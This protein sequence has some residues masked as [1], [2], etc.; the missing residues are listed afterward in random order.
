MKKVI[1]FLT[2]AA[3]LFGASNTGAAKKVHSIGDSTMANYDES[4]TVTRGTSR[5]SIFRLANT[6]WKYAPPT[7]TADGST[8]SD[9]FGSRLSLHSGKH[10]WRKRS[11]SLP[12]S[13]PFVPLHG[14]SS[15][16]GG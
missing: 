4:A 1:A 11:M 8:I 15:I 16:S 7:I 14:L 10:V 9:T 13:S 5:S 12:H 6:D 3:I 2:G